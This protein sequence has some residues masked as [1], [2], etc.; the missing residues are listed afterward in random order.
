MKKMRSKKAYRKDARKN[1]LRVTVSMDA[2]WTSAKYA[3]E[4][5]DSRGRRAPYEVGQNWILSWQLCVLNHETGAITT[6]IIY[7]AGPTK[8]HRKK[9]TTLIG[10]ALTQAVHDG[11]IPDFPHSIN[12][13]MFFARA[14]LSTVSDYGYWKQ[15]FAMVRKTYTTS[16]QRAAMNIPTP[17]G[18]RVSIRLMDVSLMAAAGT[19]LADIGEGLGVPKVELPEGYSK[20]RM[21]LFLQGDKVTFEEYA[22]TDAV[23]TARYCA[24]VFDLFDKLGIRASS[25]TLGSIGVNLSEKILSDNGID[26]LKFY[27][28]DKEVDKTSAQSRSR[29]VPIAALTGHWN[30]GAQCYHGGLNGGFALG[31]SPSGRLIYDIDVCSAYTTAMALIREP[32]W[33]HIQDVDCRDPEKALDCLAVTDAITL[34]HVRFEFPR[35]VR[36]PGLPVRAQGGQGLIYPRMGESFCTGPELLAARQLGASIVPLSGRRIEWLPTGKRPYEDFT[37]LIN[38]LR[39]ENEKSDPLL[40][41]MF[42]EIGNSVYGKTAQAVAADRTIGDAE[43]RR[44]FDTKTSKRENLGPSNISQPMFAAFTTGLVRALLIETVNKLPSGAWLGSITTDGFLC[45]ATLE[46]ID[47]S[48]PIA[49]LFREARRRITPENDAIFEYKH[50]EEGVYLIK[51]R[52]VVS[53]SGPDWRPTIPLKKPQNRLL[54]KVSYRSGRH[55]GNTVDHCAFW[56]HTI[57]E[58]TYET[59]TRVKSFIPAVKQHLSE[60][61][62]T[63]EEREA[64]LNLCWD[65]KR[66]LVNV[67]N[68]D[69]LITADTAPHETI[70]DY[71]AERN[72]Q[73][74]W[75]KS[76]RRVLK[77]AEDHTD[78]Q[79]WKTTLGTRHA[80]GVKSDNSLPPV[81]IAVGKAAAYAA[82][83]FSPS[84][85]AVIAAGLSRLCGREIPVS[86]VKDIKRRGAGIDELLGA[87]P[88]LSDPDRNFIQRLYHQNPAIISFVARLVM[89]R[90]PAEVELD[91][92][93]MLEVAYEDYET[94]READGEE[95]PS[96][97]TMSHRSGNDVQETPPLSNR[98][99]G[100]KTVTCEDGGSTSPGPGGGCAIYGIRHNRHLP[101]L[102][103]NTST[104]TAGIEP[105]SHP[106]S[107][108]SPADPRYDSCAIAAAM[109][110]LVSWLEPRLRRQ[111]VTARHLRLG[112]EAALADGTPEADQPM[113]ALAHAL[114]IKDG[115]PV[116]FAVALIAGMLSASPAGA[117]PHALPALTSR[118]CLHC[119]R[120]SNPLHVHSRW[121]ARP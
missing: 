93:I 63:M 107:Q 26:V 14:D 65:Q 23:I 121:P 64:R 92:T 2:E 17:S 59:L 61:D 39:K 49:E 71:Y 112:R 16:D 77:T 6:A 25:P 13:A 102:L 78:F 15:Q 55:T 52:G 60:A 27:G 5:V 58:R 80:V 37:R 115:L 84:P 20:E 30:Y 100:S 73:D 105:Q 36:Y 90:S 44:V 48:G 91:Q 116:E 119:P 42:K 51:T 101:P 18:R 38:R 21:D 8:K 29:R 106:P 72:A 24:K 54:A 76:Q 88:N 28:K 41:K 82:H 110:D 95:P 99:F 89:P 120:N 104:A 12:L 85:Q 114:A 97:M 19:S 74:E 9:L 31:F 1:R 45:D 117:L 34:A 68:V 50:Q 4:I 53:I 22:K 69:G 43:I 94:E 81:A 32:D 83:G 7:P 98:H 96:S 103:E 3:P 86:K 109:N 57:R 111:G 11:V 87:L 47:Q 35:E 62:L 10:L 33:A 56:M 108:P 70:D 79:G 113:A 40:E 46:E 118:V 66:R 75:R 67:R